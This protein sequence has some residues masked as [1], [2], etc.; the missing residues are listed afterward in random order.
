MGY[1]LKAEDDG[2]YTVELTDG[3]WMDAIQT[4]SEQGYSDPDLRREGGDDASLPKAAAVHLADALNRALVAQRIEPEFGDGS[5][6][7]QDLTRRIVYILQMA[8]REGRGLQLVR[9]LRK[10]EGHD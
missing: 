3:V 5:V 8:I 2:H 6:L 1:L 9:T 7:D 4:A 10:K